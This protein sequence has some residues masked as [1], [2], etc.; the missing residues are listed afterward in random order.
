MKVPDTIVGPYDNI[1][2]P[3]GSRQTDYEIELAVVIAE[4][5]R[6]LDSEEAAAAAI[7]GYTITNDVSERS[8]MLERGGRWSKGKSCETFN[9][10]GPYLVTADE[11]VDPTNLDLKLSV[12][13]EIR[14]QSNTRQMIFSVPFVVAHLSQFMVLEPGDIINTGTP[15]GVAMGMNPPQYLRADDELELWIDGIGTQRLT[16][17]SSETDTPHSDG[18]L[19]LR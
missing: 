12:N 5:C 1:L 11:P 6:Y 2:I 7:G 14:Q 8:Y 13:G 18:R 15:P 19:H 10:L 9:P 4:R 16:C 3:P 17:R